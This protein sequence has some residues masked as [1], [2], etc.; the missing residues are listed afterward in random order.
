MVGEK[1]VHVEN[2]PSRIKT[3]KTRMDKA[4]IPGFVESAHSRK[5]VWY[6][7]KNLNNFENYISFFGSLKLELINLLKTIVTFTPIK[8]N[9]K[10]EAIYNLPNVNNSSQNRSFKT[11]ARPI[12]IDSDIKL[13]LEEAF[14]TLLNEE[15]VYEGKGS[16]YTLEKIDGLLLT[17][18]KYTPTGDTPNIHIPI[19][20]MNQIT[21]TIKILITVTIL[22]VTKTI[23]KMIDLSTDKPTILHITL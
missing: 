18:Y 4:N 8:F 17:V 12:F 20:M 1:R 6:Y 21:K 2:T 16:D 7:A 10:L 15:E 22:H 19:R 9:L 5:I 3:K 13:L 11:S 23:H 14:A